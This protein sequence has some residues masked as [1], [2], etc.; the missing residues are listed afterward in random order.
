MSLLDPGQIIKAVFDDATQSIRTELVSGGIAGTVSIKDGSSSNEAKVLSDGALLVAIQDSTGNALT[1]TAG[2]LNV[3]FASGSSFELTDGTHTAAITAA[4]ALK[5]DASATTQP[6]SGT[7]SV[8]SSALPTG[9]A[10]SANQ[11]TANTSLASLDSKTTAVNTGAVTIS[12]ALPAGTNAIGS[13]SVSNFPAT[14]PVSGTVSVSN[15]PATQAVSAASLPLPT[16]ASTSANQS[17]A[18]TSL[19]TIATNT[20][21]IPAQGAAVTSASLPVNIA[22]DQT[23]PVSAASLPLPTGAAT[24]AAQ[25]T[26]Q[27][28]LNTIATNTSTSNTALASVEFVRNDYTSTGVTTAA[29]TQLIAST[30][31]ATKRLDLFDSSG[32]TLKLAVGGS[33]SEVDQ[34]LIYPGGNGQ[35]NLAIPAG[36]RIS[37]KAVSANASVGELDLNL[38][39]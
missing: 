7:V 37:I 21:H 20:G 12:T 17:T 10:T 22:S 24:S 2:A 3:T 5:V 34:F 4:G 35:L 16:G 29:Y 19:G 8:S 15:F 28:T 9:A 1:A 13:V 36:S 30:T 38:F 6:I 26:A 11:T 27:T 18:I 32:Q 39:G 25:A 31:A 14:Q 23:V 33:G